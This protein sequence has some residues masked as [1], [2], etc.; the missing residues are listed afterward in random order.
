MR[1]SLREWFYERGAHGLVVYF[2]GK[3][4]VEGNAIIE[5]EE[6]VETCSKTQTSEWSRIYGDKEHSE[7]LA[8]FEGEIMGNRK[9]FDRK[10][11]QLEKVTSQPKSF[12]KDHN[13]DE[14]PF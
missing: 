8:N 11:S 13:D 9:W 1:E 3:Y 6:N 12:D 7:G 14:I 2:T 10:R 5:T 4:D